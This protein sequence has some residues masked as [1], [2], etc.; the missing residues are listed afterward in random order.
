MQL[1]AV[2]M[3]GAIVMT[4]RLLQFVA[5]TSE[6]HWGFDFAAYWLAGS[7]VAA[8]QSPYSLEQLSGA[9]Q[10]SEKPL[11]LY[12]PVLAALVAPLSVLFDSY[13][14][15][16]WVWAGLGFA[17]L[18]L[19]VVAIARA[20]GLDR[21]LAAHLRV[22]TGV[23]SAMFVAAALAMTP[24]IGELT[25]GNVH[26]ELVGL[27]AVAWLGIRRG[28]TRGQQVAGVAIGVATLIKV[29]PGLI[30]VWFLLTRRWVAAACAVL[31]AAVVAIVLLPVTGIDSWFEYP[32]VLANMGAVADSFDSVSPTV[33]LA[34]VLGFTIARVVVTVG[35][36]ALVVYAARS[37]PVNLGFGIAVAASTL[38][39]PSVLHHYLAVLVIPL[40]LAASA[41]VNRWVLLAS[42]LLL[43]GGQQMALGDAAWILSRVPQTIGWALLLAVMV[44]GRPKEA[45]DGAPGASGAAAPA[46]AGT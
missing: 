14:D 42:Y 2:L 28:T 35:G 27:L 36:F 17:L 39:A 23:A 9:F 41:G 34:P 43:W 18:I 13:R 19:A 45:A 25:V 46:G 24:I 11:Y 1:A 30:V 4:F 29:F 8:G 20:E 44:V 31:G 21:P 5:L 7:H 12:P 26:L 10:P 3:V 22:P 6:G 38:I 33:W 15:A 40:L 16:M 37:R 32:R